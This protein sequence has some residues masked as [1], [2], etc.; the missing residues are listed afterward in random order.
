MKKFLPTMTLFLDL[1]LIPLSLWIGSMSMNR[2]KPDLVPRFS[3]FP[4]Y[5]SMLQ[6]FEFHPL[7][8]SMDLRFPVSV[9]QDEKELLL[10]KNLENPYLWY[11]TEF[12]KET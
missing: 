8:P 2:K 12:P 7:K 9:N 6:S 1:V 3:D 4:E 5:F 11:E 10:K